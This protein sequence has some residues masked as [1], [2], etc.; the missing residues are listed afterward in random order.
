[1]KTKENK[2]FVTSRKNRLL[3]QDVREQIII[4]KINN[5]IAFNFS[6]YLRTP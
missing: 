2:I 6:K 5:L 4:E 3:K 1:M